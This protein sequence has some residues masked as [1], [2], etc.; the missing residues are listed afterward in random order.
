MSNPEVRA[1]RQEVGDLREEVDSLRG[2]LSRLRRAVSDLRLGADYSESRSDSK[3]VIEEE[4][5]DSYSVVSEGNSRSG[6]VGYRPQAAGSP[7]RPTTSLSSSSTPQPAAVVTG[8][9]HN[10]PVLSWEERFAIVDQISGWIERTLGGDHRGT[11]GREKIPLQSRYWVV[12]RDYAGQIYTPV[13][14][15]TQW[16]SAKGLVKRGHDCGD[17]IF[18]GFPSEQEGKRAVEGAGL[19]WPARFER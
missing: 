1:L 18:I 7:I 19:R 16:G 9:C 3:R 11:S 13:K 10:K 2:D 4:S 12:I 6:S 15:F 14:V 17:S 5:E 8:A